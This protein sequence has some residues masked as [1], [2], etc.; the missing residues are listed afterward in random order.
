MNRF[1]Q[2][3]CGKFR[4]WPSYS[5][6]ELGY[7]VRNTTPVFRPLVYFGFFLKW[8]SLFNSAETQNE[9]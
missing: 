1:R 9:Q 5:I 2:D 8:G 7:L 3:I 4:A 6:V